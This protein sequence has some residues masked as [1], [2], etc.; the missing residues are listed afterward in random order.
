MQ[1]AA[2]E[3]EPIIEF[4]ERI[5]CALCGGTERTVHLAFR[6]IPVMRC[7]DCGFLYSGR[8]M[9]PAVMLAYYR[10]GFGSERHMQGQIVNARTNGAVLERL[11]DLKRTKRWLDIGT[12]YGFLLKRL[13]DRWKIA[14]EGVELSLQEASYARDKLGLEVHSRPLSEAGLPAAGF[15]VVSCFEVIE[16][17][18]DPK[19]FLEELAVYVRPGGALVV[20]TDNFESHA[21]RQLKAGFPKWIPHTHIS[22]FGPETLRK[23]MRGLSGFKLE[24]EASYTPWDLAG[25]QL[26]SSFRPP[27]P[28]ELAYDLRESLASEMKRKYR[29]YRLR[30]LS[31]PIW[32]GM[33]LRPTLDGGA[34]MYAVCRKQA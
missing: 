32:T 31:S 16:H 18:P 23:C 24:K 28:A 5:R 33:N 9:N 21:A 14:V 26:L 22:H 34:L 4:E 19:A 8:T 12:G 17:I 10:E 7:S 2:S 13:M 11:L 25:R 15:D 1:S 3:N 30:Y 29:L 27:K 20:M 6:D